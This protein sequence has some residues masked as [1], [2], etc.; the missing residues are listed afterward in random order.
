VSL[1]N[2]SEGK[3][4]EALE[5]SRR[6]F[7]LS[8]NP[9]IPLTHRIAIKPNLTSAKRS[10][11]THAIVTDPYVVEGLVDGLTGSGIHAGRIYVREGLMVDQPG[12]GYLEMAQRTGV[13]YADDDSRS[14][15]LKECPDGVVF[16]RTRYLGPFNYPDSYLINV[17]KFKTHSMGLTLCVKNLQGT[18]IPPYIRFCGGLQSAIAGEFQPDAQAH[19][20]ALHA[21]HVAAGIP[22]WDTARGPWMEMWAQRTLDSYTLI[23]NSIGLNVIE[24]IYAQNGDGFDG[25]PGPEGIPE[26]F[27]TNV[28]IFGKDAF[29]VDILG[30]W[31]GGHEPGNFG[32]FHI[33]R[34][35]GV[36]TALDPRTIPIY[37]WEDRGPKPVKLDHFSRTPMVA[38]YLEKTGEPRFHMCDEP[39][40]YPSERA[41]SG[42]PAPSIRVLG[43]SRP[44]NTRAS[45]V[46]E[47]DLDKDGNALVDVYDFAGDRVAILSRGWHEKGTHMS[48]WNILRVNPGNYYC[49]LQTPGVARTVRLSVMG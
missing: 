18:N 16:R 32:L 7:T 9:G 41:A 8:E 35:R 31:L 15:T 13:H 43:E 21:R 28:L 38:P 5:L 11:I 1:K 22:R 4:R 26:I 37:E 24:G 3:R 17:A 42:A 40:A 33:G 20:D 27:M 34:E 29:R 23:R 36:S 49:R 39:Y 10:G 30:H 48:E 14:A 6:I 44:A 46:L 19:V 45:I 47:Y 12:V 25:G 2:D